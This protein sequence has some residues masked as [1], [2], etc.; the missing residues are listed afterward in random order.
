M[1]QLKLLNF[2]KMIANFANNLV[3][4]F[5]PLIIYQATGSLT[6]SIIYLVAS[7]FIRLLI[8]MSLK[9][10]Y[11]KYPQL[12][13]LLRIIPIALYN[14]FIFVL[15]ANLILG[16]I[17][18]CLFISLD[19]SLNGLSKEIIFN[20]SSLT[21]KHEKSSLGVTRV[22]EQAGVIIALVVGGFLLD[23]N[24]AI[25]LI[26]S[27]SLYTISVIPLVMYYV[28]CKKQKTFNK[29]ATSNAI[30]SLNKKDEN[31]RIAKKL[32]KKLL[33]NYAITYFSFA[34]VD[35]L[36]S[37]YSLFIFMKLGEFS[38]AGILNAIFH[39]FYA[40]GFYVASI[41]NEKKD[42]TKLVSFFCVLIGVSVMALPFIDIT[43]QFILVCLIYG[44]IG[45]TY[46]FISLFV[47]DRLLIKCRIMGISNSGLFV[48]ESSC[49]CAY[50][51]GYAC[52]FFGLIGIFIATMVTMIF[53]SF[54]IPTGEEKTRKNL[55]DYLQ[56]NEIQNSK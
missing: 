11:G 39:S 17:G 20:Y 42:I 31:K 22:F 26:L 51:T 41:I 55:V 49:I 9:N 54:I 7:N 45:T 25:V 21:Q 48:R 46:P 5:L 32:S 27:L 4:A 37:T 56:N 19:N 14:I 16:V 50:V 10:L 52:G 12:F 3:G 29:E 6:Y 15:D 13:L 38:T 44:I 28:K 34:F 47:L 8:T 53:A 40:I 1:D 18:V 43:T 30:Y 24:K 35:L 2:H 33:I 23:I 36:Q